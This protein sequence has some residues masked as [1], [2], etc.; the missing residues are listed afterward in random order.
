MNIEHMPAITWDV[1]L[2]TP[3][4][5]LPPRH[6]PFVEARDEV[7]AAVAALNLACNAVEASAGVCHATECGA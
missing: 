5:L 7:P 2:T 3:E 4:R 1:K 6:F